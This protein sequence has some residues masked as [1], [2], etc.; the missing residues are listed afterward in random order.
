[1]LSPT[2]RPNA[3]P[4]GRGVGRETGSGGGGRGALGRERVRRWGRGQ[5]V[6]QSRG[7]SVG[8][9]LGLGLDQNPL[10]GSEGTASR[11]EG[12][13][14]GP[15]AAEDSPMTKTGM[16]APQ[17]TGM[18]VASADIQNCRQETVQT[19]RGTPR[20]QAAPSSTMRS[21]PCLSVR[22][23]LPAIPES[24]RGEERTRTPEPDGLG[25][26]LTL[27]SRSGPIM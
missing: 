25:S 14:L 18:V 3:A 22:H 15:Q 27:P 8:W 19:G 16:K 20:P 6:T 2:R 23:K 4:S 7:Q 13:R 24:P 26:N 17:G 11:W 21:P 1:M 10:P 9:G 5:W 12:C